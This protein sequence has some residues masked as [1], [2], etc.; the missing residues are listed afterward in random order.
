MGLAASAAQHHAEKKIARPSPTVLIKTLERAGFQ[1]VKSENDQ[2]G[3]VAHAY[4]HPDG[5]AAI[6]IPAQEELNEPESCIVKLLNNQT[7]KVGPVDTKDHPNNLLLWDAIRRISKKEARIRAAREEGKRVAE[8]LKAKPPAERT[9][10][11]EQ[12]LSVVKLVTERAKKGAVILTQ[13]V[14]G[15]PSHV[16]RAVEM[17]GEI[18]GKRYDPTVLTGDRNYGYRLALLKKLFNRDRVLVAETGV[19][20]LTGAFYTAMGAHGK[21]VTQRAMDFTRRCEDLCQ[22]AREAKRAAAKIERK[23]L[24]TARRAKATTLT[25]PGRV[26][27]ISKPL[28]RK[29]RAEA[30]AVARQEIQAETA[31]SGPTAQPHPGVKGLVVTD[32]HGFRLLDNKNG[33]VSLKLERC[34]SQGALQVYDTGKKLVTGVLTPELTK[35]VRPRKQDFAEIEMFIDSL[36]TSKSEC[37]SELATNLEVAKAM[38]QRKDALTMLQPLAASLPSPR[39]TANRPRITPASVQLL[40]DPAAGLVMI[41]LERSNS[42]G[43]M[44]VYNDGARITV[45]VCPPEQLIKFHSVNVNGHAPTTED[46]ARAI[47]QLLNPEIPG[48]AV[49]SVAARHLTAV[50]DGIKEKNEMATASVAV[51]RKFAATKSTKPAAAKTAAKKSTTERAPR[52]SSLAGKTIKVL[53]AK[54]E[55]RKG[56]KRQIGMDIILKSKTTDAALPLLKKAGCNASF[57]AF[58]VKTKLIKLV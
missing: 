4:A 35:M 3:V 54:H 9:E 37:S 43:A 52:T 6:Y 32:I 27:T 57:I 17:L 10:T 1:F 33:F 13:E 50:L 44:V 49:T 21:T 5:R 25:V 19:A 11:L 48:V 29:A 53:N 41:Q 45:G 24:K 55:A 2:I 7:L 18:T 22:A 14:N 15:V 8:E 46:I 58:A 12:A 34:N 51:S 47:N 42:Q 36:L 26:L 39:I 56:T 23:A 40:E 31:Q 28:S 20:S 16:V 38:L 30:D